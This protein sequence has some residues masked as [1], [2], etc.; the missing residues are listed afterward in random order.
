MFYG[1]QFWF[2]KKQYGYKMS[3]VMKILR[4]VSRNNRKH[5]IRNGFIQS[6]VGFDHVQ[7]ELVM[8]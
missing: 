2:K 6:K 1:M 8:H 3:I 7:Q 4:W 5:W